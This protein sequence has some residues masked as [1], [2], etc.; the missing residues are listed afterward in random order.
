MG[1]YGINKLKHSK[2]KNINCKLFV[3]LPLRYFLRLLYKFSFELTPR[4]EFT[5]HQIYG[6][7]GNEKRE[8]HKSNKNRFK[9]IISKTSWRELREAVHL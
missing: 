9:S 7:Q 4:D 3:T 1:C 6:E 2:Y 8:I 5:Q